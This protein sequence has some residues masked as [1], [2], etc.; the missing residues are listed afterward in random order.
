MTT[1]TRTPEE[2]QQWAPASGTHPGA[3]PRRTPWR[4]SAL[5]LVVACAALGAFVFIVKTASGA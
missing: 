4:A 5:H 2:A 3:T 1:R